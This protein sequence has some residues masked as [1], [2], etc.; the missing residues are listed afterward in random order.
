M[1]SYVNLIIGNFIGV[2]VGGLGAE[3]PHNVFR[4]SAGFFSDQYR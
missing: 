2:K 3:A 4:P 1:F